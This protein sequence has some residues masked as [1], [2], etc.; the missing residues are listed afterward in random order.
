MGRRSVILGV[1]AAPGGPETLPKGG[2]LRPHILEGFPG[3]PGPAR[4]QKR[5]PKNPAG[6]PSGTQMRFLLGS[7]QSRF[8][9][10]ASG[11]FSATIGSRRSLAK[12]T[13]LQSFRH[14]EFVFGAKARNLPRHGRIIGLRSFFMVR[15]APDFEPDPLERVSRPSLAGK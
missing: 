3:R 4:P 2:G 14:F 15:S 8:Q 7:F 10:F 6:L 12:Q 1:W 11:W 9:A 5:T 13:Y